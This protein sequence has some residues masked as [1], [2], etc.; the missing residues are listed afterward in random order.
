M[1]VTLSSIGPGMIMSRVTT[2][3]VKY[4]IQHEVVAY[5]RFTPQE[6]RLMDTSLLLTKR[7]LT[8]T[9]LAFVLTRK[10]RHHGGVCSRCFWKW[11]QLPHMLW[12]LWRTKVPSKLRS[13]YLSEL[14][15]ENG[16]EKKEG[17]RMPRLQSR[18]W[19]SEGWSRSVSKESFV[20]SIAG[21]YRTKREKV[22]ETSSRKL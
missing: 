2:W 19:Y 17:N 1:A 6:F 20:S 22:Y 18:V 21:E 11:T 15:W 3:L 12:G 5:F 10:H 13:Q 14:S 8:L 4:T 7:T 16:K 9:A